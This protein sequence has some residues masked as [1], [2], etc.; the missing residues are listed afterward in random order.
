[1]L[2]GFFYGSHNC[3]KV[4]LQIFESILQLHSPIRILDDQVNNKRDE[5]TY[6]YIQCIKTE[7]IVLWIP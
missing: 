1:M 6:K 4:H 3:T 2:K 7:V 5:E